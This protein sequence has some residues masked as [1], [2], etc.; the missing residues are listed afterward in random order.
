M[1]E[2]EE[3]LKKDQKCA[4]HS[5]KQLAGRTC[6][7]GSPHHKPSW[8]IHTSFLLQCNTTQAGVVVLCL[9]S[10]LPVGAISELAMSHPK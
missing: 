6:S 10:R 9:P 7:C 5:R 2:T 1:K 4:M 8:S 3:V